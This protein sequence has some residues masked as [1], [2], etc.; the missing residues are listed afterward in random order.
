MIS[1]I[2]TLAFVGLI[3]YLVVTFI[4]MPPVFKTVILVVVAL[5][6]IVWLMNVFGIVDVPVPR[7]R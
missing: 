1:L 3:V 5:C 4:P 2:V 7:V 6:L